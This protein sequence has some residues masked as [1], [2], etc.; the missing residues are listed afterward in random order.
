M[1]R[2]I[3]L[4]A[5]ISGTFA[6]QPLQTPSRSLRRTRLHVTGSEDAIRDEIARRNAARADAPRV[7][8]TAPEPP[9]PLG[10]ASL[11]GERALQAGSK[12]V[13]GL[14]NKTPPK[15]TEDI[16]VLGSGWGAAALVG[17]LG[18]NGERVTVVSPRNYFLFT[19]ML[20]GAAVGTVEY[21]SI[22][23]P[24]RSLNKHASYLEATA[25]AVDVE[26]KV[27]V[28]EAVVCEGSQCSIDEFELPY[29]R[30]VVSVGATT[31]TF[32]VP[33]VR[34]HCLFLK[35][36]QDADKLRKALGNAFERASL[37]TLS[38]D[39]RR[40]ALSFCVVGAG[41]TGVEFCGELRDFLASDAARYYPELVGKARVTLLEATDQV[42]GPFDA[43]LRAEALVELRARRLSRENQDIAGVDVKLGAQVTEVNGTHV[44]L[45]EAESVP[46]GF[47]VWAT[48]NGA[49]SV[50]SET[51]AA[52]G[53]GAQ[54]EAQSIARGRLAVDPWLRVLGAPRGEVYS[55]GDCA[56]G[57]PSL[58]ATAQ[59]AA[60]QGEY[61]SNLLRGAGSYDLGAST[62]RRAGGRRLDELF[63][64]ADDDAVIARPF[65]FLNLGILAYVGDSKALAQVSL[66]DS[67]LKDTGRR[68]FALWRSVYLAKQ[69]SFR[70]RVLVAGDWARDRVFGRDITRF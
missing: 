6:L 36:I 40:R 24:V 52:L 42:L 33:G 60:Q 25:T 34:E 61:L 53:E 67:T 2:C 15:P 63:C 18:A 10:F 35:Q 23:Q 51:V 37:P 26:R 4:L 38:A 9:S 19:P 39:E 65:Q 32:G 45:G 21:R 66:G 47:C 46:Y 62:P 29:D 27:V 64:E 57:S 28:C 22:T 31:N 70:N 16:V 12:A 48:G 50:V 13:D 1:R 43:S 55:I 69:V 58:P 8:T 20:A 41:P 3:A 68:A 5:L 30:V 54:A 59:V 7:P 17:A 49:V 56:C 44:L 14:G 11:L